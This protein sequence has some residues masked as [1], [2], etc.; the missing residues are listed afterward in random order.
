MKKLFESNKN[1]AKAGDQD[2]KIII[3]TLQM[4]NLSK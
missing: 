2:V 3:A 4:F 1:V